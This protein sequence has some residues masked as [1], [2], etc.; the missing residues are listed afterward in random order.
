LTNV[1]MPD[2]RTPERALPSLSGEGGDQAGGGPWTTS[3]PRRRQDPTR[4]NCHRDV[5]L[6]RRPPPPGR[7][8][9]RL[10]RG[11]PP[12]Q[13]ASGRP[14]ALHCSNAEPG[15]M[16]LAP[17]EGR[18]GWCSLGLRL[19][20]SGGGGRVCLALPVG[21]LSR[22]GQPRRAA[23]AKGQRFGRQSRP[24]YEYYVHIPDYVRTQRK[25]GPATREGGVGRS[26][27][28]RPS[29]A[30]RRKSKGLRGQG[31]WPRLREGWR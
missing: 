16:A 2:G 12:R 10:G 17:S 3:S 25:V 14:P 22:H 4:V 7:G 27:L 5:R 30:E 15:T 1:T 26:A 13:A 18:K 21:G 11:H 24:Y 23:E 31:I 29:R 28:A 19:L 20:Y 6:P 9:Q 8:T